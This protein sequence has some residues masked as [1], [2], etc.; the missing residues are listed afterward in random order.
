MLY[1]EKQTKKLQC[2]FNILR[3]KKRFLLLLTFITFHYFFFFTLCSYLSLK[4]NQQKMGVMQEFHFY[5]FINYL[6]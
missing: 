1:S 5:L 3:E 2:L 6:F 4:K